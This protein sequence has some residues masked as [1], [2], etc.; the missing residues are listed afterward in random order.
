MKQW[1]EYYKKAKTIYQTHSPFLYEIYAHVLNTDRVYYDFPEIEKIRKELSGS[2]QSVECKEFDAG[3]KVWKGKN[4]TVSKIASSGI[5]DEKRC[6][7]LFNLVNYFA[8]NNI[9]EFGTSL[10][11]NTLYLATSRKKANIDTVEGNKELQAIARQNAENLSLNN[12]NF[13]PCTFEEYLEKLPPELKYDII[14][15]NGNHTYEATTWYFQRLLPNISDKGVVVVNDIHWSEG[16][17]NAWNVLKSH[18][19]IQTS[20]ETAYVGY[21][22]LNKD[23]PKIDHTHISFWCKPWQIG[24]FPQDV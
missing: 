16:M 14:Y 18:P 8:P 17:Y 7:N 22:F 13:H 2:N 9:L 3:S 15:L 24:L 21:L 20:V 5:S 19:R 11:I 1:L 4:R 12:I 23:F 6:R 10:G